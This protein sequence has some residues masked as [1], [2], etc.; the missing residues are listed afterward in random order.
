[1][2]AQQSGPYPT[3]PTYITYS[4]IP[5]WNNTPSPMPSAPLSIPLSTPVPGYSVVPLMPSD[6]S[7][8]Q[9]KSQLDQKF[10]NLVKMFELPPQTADQLQILANCK[11]VMLCD[12]SSS[13]QTPIAEEASDPF[14]QKTSTRWA[15][16]K[17]LAAA[18]INV[19]TCINPQGLDLYF[20]NREPVIGVTETSRLVGMFQQLPN[21]S[22]PL[23]R[24]LQDIYAAT[25]SVP[26]SQQILILV[27]GD[28]E[29]S[30]ASRD[31]FYQTCCAKRSN[32]HLSFAECTDD[33]DDME[34]LDEFD[35]K[36]P[37]FDNTDDFRAERER[38]RQ[39]QGPTFPFTYTHYVIKILLATFVKYYFKL[40]QQ[41]VTSGSIGGSTAPSSYS[42]TNQGQSCCLIQ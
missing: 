29:D 3:N 39:Q 12:D 36:I 17:K 23:R 11:I 41:K 31:Q 21:G 18:C 5:N 30:D 16:L 35:N 1:M 20:L 32:V 27:I 19:V 33:P 38:V 10:A 6:F 28:G 13:M 25:S 8:D 26:D 14:A 7:R 4:S 9:K 40:D 37:N 42:N 2:T 15:E 24:A 34:W 22:T